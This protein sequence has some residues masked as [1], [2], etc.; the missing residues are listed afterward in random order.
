MIQFIQRKEMKTDHK[1]RWIRQSLVAAM[2]LGTYGYAGKIV[3]DAPEGESLKTATSTANQQF[4]FGGWNLDNISV[5]IIG[6]DN[7]VFNDDGS[8]TPMGENMTFESDIMTQGELR[9][10]LHGKDWPVGE[11]SGIKIINGD[12]ETKHGKPENCI[13]TSSYLES[14]YLNAGNKP[15]LCSSDFQTHKRFKINLLPSTVEGVESGWGKPL[16]LTFNLVEGDSSTQRYQVLQKINNYTGKRLNGY[17]L[18][19][20]DENG[21][22]NSALTISL[23]I[24]EGT[25]SENTPDGSDIWTID[26]LA[27]MSHGLWG[28]ADSDTSGRDE[29]FDENGFF[30]AQRVY[31]A[32]T[33]NETKS[34]VSYAGEMRGGNYQALFGNWLTRDWAPIGIFHDDDQNPETDGILKVFWG[35]PEHTGT[36]AWHKGN[37][38]G[39][40]LATEEDL[41]LL[42]GEWYEEEVIEDVLNLG[43]NYIINIGDNHAIGKTFTIRITPSVDSNQTLPNHVLNPVPLSM[44]GETGSVEDT[45]EGIVT[46]GIFG[47]L[48]DE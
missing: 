39:W 7:G 1:N 13:M 24:G 2:L 45:S 47:T 6:D 43:L 28:A 9:G 10:H 48:D 37:D 31:F 5:H 38:Q 33:L 20:L 40:A 34:M 3:T 18:E 25:D 27:N 46:M 30:D 29:H 32:T 17:K 15:V 42:S 41:L 11:P 22:E 21:L 35:D 36:S 14:G 8:Y 12:T 4:G 23:G 44:Y 16:E 26:E 19:V